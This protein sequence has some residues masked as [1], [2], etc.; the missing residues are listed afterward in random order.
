MH[1]L[2]S[3]AL[4]IALAV[5]SHAAR[6][7][8]EIPDAPSNWVT[9]RAAFLSSAATTKLSARL[10]DY[11]RATGHQLIV[12]I[13]RSTGAVPIEDWSAR[14]FERWHVGRRGLDDGA[15]LFVFG[16]DR[17][18]R[19]EVGYGLEERLPDA[20][21]G[22]IIQT[23][24]VPLLRAGDKDGAISA[25]VEGIIAAIGGDGTGR[26][27]APVAIPGWLLVVGGIIFVLLLGVLV[28]HPALAAWLLISLG[29][30][31]RRGSG[32]WGGSSGGGFFGGGGRSGGGGASG[33]W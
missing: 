9:D 20:L 1:R 16:D 13:D 2:R 8:T 12:Y 18:V 11:E 21:A 22:R 7:T 33:S 29:S 27:E 32:G 10:A 31:R 6:A 19:I 25:G 24:V 15:V 5:P 26:T 28:T 23:D 17:R 14:A 4:L 3:C 30:N